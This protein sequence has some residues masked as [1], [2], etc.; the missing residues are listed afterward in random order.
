M[1]NF[2][3]NEIVSAT[4][5]V[6]Q[7]SSIMSSLVNKTLDKIAVVRNNEMEAVILS[8]DEYEQLV[9]RAEAASQKSV[10]DYFGCISSE[11]ADLMEKAVSECRKVDLNEW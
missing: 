8:F 7:F 10:R 5:I 11:E 9:M 2:N 4:Q 1:V 3:R 6:R